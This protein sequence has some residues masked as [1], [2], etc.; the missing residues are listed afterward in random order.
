M[1]FVRPSSRST[2][3]SKRCPATV[4]VAVVAGATVAVEV[5]AVAEA[6][7]ATAVAVDTAEA[8]V[9]P[10]VEVAGRE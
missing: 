10:W 7:V 1:Y 3:S 5:D 4:E 2:L 8:T 6:V 9:L